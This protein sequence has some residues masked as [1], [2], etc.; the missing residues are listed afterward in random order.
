MIRTLFEF[1]IVLLCAPVCAYSQTGDDETLHPHGNEVELLFRDNVQGDTCLWLGRT[2]LRQGRLV[3]DLGQGHSVRSVIV[4]GHRLTPPTGHCNRIDITRFLHVGRNSFA[5]VATEG[6][7]ARQLDAS[8]CLIE[9]NP[10]PYTEFLPGRIWLDKA[11]MPIQAH[12]FQI[13]EHDCAYYWIGEDKSLTK[14]GS[15]IWTYGIRC[16][17]STDLYNWQDMGHIIP[18][19]TTD[20]LSPLHPSQTLDRPHIIYCGKTGKWVCWIKSMDEDG[21]FVILQA[22][23]LMGPYRMIRK[24]KPEGF[25]VGDFDLYADP[26]TGKGYVW[27]E[28]PHYSMI[29]A[30]LTDDFTNVTDQ[31]STHFEGLLPPDT[32]EALTHFVWQGKHYILSSGTTGYYP[33]PTRACCFTDPH[34][35]YTDLGTVCVGDTHHDSFTSQFTD[36]VALSQKNL[37]IAVADRWM[38]QIEGTDE[39]TRMAELMRGKYKASKPHPRDFGQPQTK[40][41]H[42]VVRSNWDVTYNATY[43]FLPIRFVDGRPTI[44]WRDAWSY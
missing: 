3:I 37:L 43:V 21:Y 9:P 20:C 29:C 4:N 15:N 38:P 40:D 32:R 36:V 26:G 18:P 27:F 17:R 42:L 2:E 12:G 6:T 28:R 23:E 30:T 41:K 5:F 13:L 19:D 31:Y 44:E 14:C 11:G 22:D 8:I 7:N 1:L 34:G 16:Y 35:H 24:L 10:L 25:G 39:P 33:N